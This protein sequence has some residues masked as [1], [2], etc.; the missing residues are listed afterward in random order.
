[1]RESEFYEKQSEGTAMFI[2]VMGWVI[3]FFFILAAVI[4]AFITMNTAVASRR[5]EIGTMLAI[6]FSSWA[7]LGSF[8]LESL[9]LAGAGALLGVVAAFGVTF[10]KFSMMNFMTWSEVV[11]SFTLTPGVVVTAVLVGGV[12]GLV[13]G[14]I[15]AA[16]AA[17]L[18][19]IDAMRG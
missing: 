12:M 19:P 1:M 5:R 16:R 15:P 14:I 17:R 11:F 18:S 4:G 8:L 13:G 9:L 6:G 3:A 7:I 2:T 10:A